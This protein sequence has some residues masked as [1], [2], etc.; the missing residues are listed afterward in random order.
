MHV[1]GLCVKKRK[2][3]H[4]KNTICKID[5]IDIKYYG[6]QKKDFILRTEFHKYDPHHLNETLRSTPRLS[7]HQM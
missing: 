1:P 5:S 2:R 4:E 7:I 3:V 6:S